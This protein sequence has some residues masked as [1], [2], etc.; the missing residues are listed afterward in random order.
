MCG[1][2]FRFVSRSIPTDWDRSRKTKRSEVDNDDDDDDGDH[3]SCDND[4]APDSIPALTLI[5]H[6]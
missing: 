3:G 1:Y 4:D 2:F 6:E 5:K